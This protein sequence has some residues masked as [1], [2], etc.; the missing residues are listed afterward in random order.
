MKGL[1]TNISPDTNID[2]TNIGA[3]Q[4]TPDDIHICIRRIHINFYFNN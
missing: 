3:I 1:Y 4:T 2:Y